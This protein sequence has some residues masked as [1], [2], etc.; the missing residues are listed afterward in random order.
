VVADEEVPLGASVL[1]QRHRSTIAIRQSSIGFTLVELLVVLVL[2]GMLVAVVF[3]SI[4][5]GISTVRLRTCCREIAATLRL[6]RSKAV[7]EQ[8]VYLVG[9]DLEKNKV[10]LSSADL[11]YQRFFA[12]PEGVSIKKAVVLKS[13]QEED[14]PHRTYFFS[15]NGMTEAFEIL[16]GNDRG[17][18]LKVIQDS[19]SQSPR[20]EDVPSESEM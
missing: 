13:E 5:R 15:P 16:I 19:L 12:L 17:R 3:P 1:H 18:E 7:K 9:F 10:E 4:G 6:A 20:I 11:R 8:Q 2:V 14:R